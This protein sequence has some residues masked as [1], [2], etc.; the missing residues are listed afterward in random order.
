[1]LLPGFASNMQDGVKCKVG[2]INYSVGGVILK[3]SRQGGAE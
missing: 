3:R 2:V 1:V